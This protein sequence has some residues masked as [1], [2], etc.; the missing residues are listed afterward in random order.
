MRDCPDPVGLLNAACDVVRNELVP[1]LPE[2][3][4]Y[5]GLMVANA[6]AIVA[7]QLTAMSFSERAELER[8]CALLGESGV[9]KAHVEADAER[10]VLIAANRRLSREIRAGRF[11][12]GQT[13]AGRLIEHLQAT[14]RAKLAES[15][16]KALAGR[17]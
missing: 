15:N 13:G 11:D 6:L 9:P 10:A 2:K 16:P 3:L 7:R 17:R 8:V 1:T 4:R 12:P 14:T 5:E